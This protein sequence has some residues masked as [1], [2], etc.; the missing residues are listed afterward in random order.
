MPTGPAM[1]FA[2]ELDA[3][4][5][6]V[7]YRLAPE[8]PFPAAHNDCYETLDWVARNAAGY[9]LDVNRIALW[10]TSAGGQLAA[11]IALRDSNEHKVSRIKHVNLVVP[12]LCAPQ[13]YP[14]S[15][16]TES[17]SVYRFSSKP[18][19]GDITKAM[20]QTWGK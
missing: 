18:T 14:A 20:R 8:Y 16:M 15:I 10:G 11:S 7:D 3:I 2:S 1:F 12:V 17:S 5:I 13:L 19:D 9:S 6:L 4:V